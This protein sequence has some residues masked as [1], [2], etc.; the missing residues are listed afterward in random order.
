M[1]AGRSRRDPLNHAVVKQPNVMRTI[2]L[3]HEG[4]ASIKRYMSSKLNA[5]RKYFPQ[6]SKRLLRY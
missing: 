1:F 4:G 2:V 5:W 3:Q 6:C